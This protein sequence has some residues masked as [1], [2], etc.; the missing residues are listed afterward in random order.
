MTQKCKLTILKLLVSEPCVRRCRHIETQYNHALTG[1]YVSKQSTN[2]G[3]RQQWWMGHEWLN[4][5]RHMYIVVLSDPEVQRAWHMLILSPICYR[6]FSPDIR[7][8]KVIWNGMSDVSSTWKISSA[9]VYGFR[10]RTRSK[11]Q[12]R[13]NLARAFLFIFSFKK[14]FSALKNKKTWNMMFL[15]CYFLRACELCNVKVNIHNIIL[16]LLVKV[17]K[18]AKI[19]NRYNQVPHLTQDTNGKVANSQ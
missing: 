4:A 7:T 17:S 6:L 12:V 16:Q 3:V 19:R 8:N 13:S 15:V 10:H 1:A 11:K 5:Y 14:G 18:G 2:G 9:V